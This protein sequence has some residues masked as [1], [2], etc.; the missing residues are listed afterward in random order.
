[1]KTLSKRVLARD[2][3]I[4]FSKLYNVSQA[5]KLLKDRASAKFNETLEAIFVC[6]I[7][8]RK[9]DQ[10]FRGMVTLPH[11]TGKTMR[12]AVFAKGDLIEKALQAGAHVAGDETLIDEVQAG[13]LDF[14]LCIATPDMMV[15]MSKLGK[16]LGPKG[17]MPNP[18]LGTVTTDVGEAIRKAQQ[19][20]VALRPEKAG[21][22]HASFGKINFSLDDLEDNFNVLKDA[23]LALK[24]ATIKAPLIKKVYLS[25][26]M[27]FSLA[28]DLSKPLS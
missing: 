13:R 25:S 11:G 21:I 6:A 8:P 18:K 15:N 14:D 22:V 26:T 9:T 4:D 19:G 24:P 3:G 17:L 27:G 1:M 23:L 2:K 28:L 20:Q 10:I 12:I 5:L 16:V 7:D